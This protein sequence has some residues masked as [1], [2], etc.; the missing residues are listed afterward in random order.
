MVTSIVYAIA[1]LIIG[2]IIY[3]FDLFYTTESMSRVR[4]S[5]IF[6]MY[7]CIVGSGWLIW[8]MYDIQKYVNMMKDYFQNGTEQTNDFQ[9]VEGNQK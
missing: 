8:L 7:L 6:N 9:L 4:S 1:I 5:E 2:I 3:F